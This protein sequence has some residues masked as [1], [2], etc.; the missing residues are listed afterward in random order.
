MFVSVVD[1]GDIE[2]SQECQAINVA[3]L[4]GK[5]T[6]QSGAR[7]HHKNHTPKTN[8]TEE[9]YSEGK[10]QEGGFLCSGQKMS[11]K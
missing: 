9:I 3:F 2:I 10:T 8:F 5:V 7:G 1:V 11:V 6:W 4:K